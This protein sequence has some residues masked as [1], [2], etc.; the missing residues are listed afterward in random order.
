MLIRIGFD[1]TFDVPAPTAMVLMLRVHPAVDVA[2]TTSF[3][4]TTLE[5]FVVVTDEMRGDDGAGRQEH[6]RR[7]ADR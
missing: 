4:P 7:L 3:G 2:L 6:S 1:L 5:G